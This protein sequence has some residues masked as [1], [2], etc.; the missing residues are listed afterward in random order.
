MF[1]CTAEFCIAQNSKQ[2][3]WLSGK[4]QTLP[5]CPIH[6]PFGQYSIVY[7]DVCIACT[8]ILSVQKQV[9]QH[10]LTFEQPLNKFFPSS[11]NPKSQFLNKST[12]EEEIRAMLRTRLY[13]YPHCGNIIQISAFYLR[14]MRKP[15]MHY[16]QSISHISE[17]F[18]ILCAKAVD[19]ISTKK[20][21]PWMK[22][23][24]STSQL[25][26]NTTQQIITIRQNLTQRIAC[27]SLK[28]KQKFIYRF[29]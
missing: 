28:I 4:S 2:S 23:M 19:N 11:L 22:S 8:E 20:R 13:F 12:T 24:D 1:F 6:Q 9:V 16:F 10:N 27:F 14:R 15:Y 5:S 17:Q 3:E 25:N 7:I 26:S 21:A 29:E 18:Y